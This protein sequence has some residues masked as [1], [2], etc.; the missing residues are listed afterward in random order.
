MGVNGRANDIYVVVLDHTFNVAPNGFFVG[1][2]STTI[3]TD[4]PDNEI[5]PGLDALGGRKDNILFTPGYDATSHFETTCLDVLEVYKR[6]M[7]EELDLT[8]LQPSL[9]EDE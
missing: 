3:E 1:I 9:E 7:G 5:I 4:T 6:V 8:T 2:V